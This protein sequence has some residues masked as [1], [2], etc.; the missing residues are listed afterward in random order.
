M[1]GIFPDRCKL[2]NVRPIYKKGNKKDI[3]NYRPV[4]LL[5]VLSKILEKLMLKRL[6]FHLEMNKILTPEQFGF[7]KGISIDNA[8][9]NLTDKILTSLDQR[10]QVGGIFCDLSKAF[11]CVDHDILLDKMQYYGV[12]GIPHRW[13]RS[14][15]Y[16]RK[17]QVYIPTLNSAIG[18][19]S[20]WESVTKGVPQGSI[21]GPLL[22][23]I[24]INDFP[25]V[26]NQGATPVIYA[27]DT[28]VL[29]TTEKDG[30]LKTDITCN[31]ERMEDRFSVNGL[32]L[33]MEKTHIMKFTTSRHQNT[34]L[35]VEYQNNLIKG[36]NS[37]KFLG[38][39]LDTNINWKSHISKLI[40]KLSSA[41]YIIRKLYSSCSLHTLKLVYYAYFHSVME[42]G[43][44]FWGDATD[45]KRIF[46]QQKKA[47]RIIMGST[48]RT[49]CRKLF[50]KLGIMTL[51]F[52][53]I[54]SLM[55]F[56]SSNL[57]IYTFNNSVHDINIRDKQ[58]L[59][60][61]TV[62]S[63]AYQKSVYYNSIKVY[64][65]LPN[66]L[67]ELVSSKASFIKQLKRHLIDNPF[68]SLDEFLES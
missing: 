48:P 54:L 64:N 17:Q 15:L 41:C 42:Y 55:R 22:F 21:L 46:L 62:R 16:N 57:D 28:S 34:D 38:I 44:A 39:E 31:L 23:L 12:Q 60:K 6:E 59:Y 45:S 18:Q 26:L 53:F 4:S 5:P 1:T 61:P 9:F 11:D 10:Q 29:I 66:T 43:I 8:I 52:Q 67:A 65:K 20:K 2:A 33:N 56:L 40:P 37:T 14:Y 51:T 50:R 3:T 49:S 68:Y 47:I 7:R 63:S 25:Y 32:N 24:Y 35:Q 36:I 58:K 27:D 19:Y 30:N 13:F